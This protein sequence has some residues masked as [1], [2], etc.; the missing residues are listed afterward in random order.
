[1]FDSA[2]A[3]PQHAGAEVAGL[4]LSKP[5]KPAFKLAIAS[6]DSDK[7]STDDTF[8]ITSV[9]SRSSISAG[10]FLKGSRVALPHMRQ[11]DT[12]SHVIGVAPGRSFAGTLSEAA[13]QRTK[14][15]AV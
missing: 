3:L 8:R 5:E 4:V 1:M 6:D 13:M 10:S 11:F 15:F 2:T 12:T 14:Q 7:D 9:R